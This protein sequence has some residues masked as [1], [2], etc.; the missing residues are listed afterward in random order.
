[1]FVSTCALAACAAAP[2]SDATTDAVRTGHSSIAEG[3]TGAVAA[4]V[5]LADPSSP[6][7]ASITPAEA[8]A[9]VAEVPGFG[10]D[11]SVDALGVLARFE[12]AA[13]APQVTPI[14]T[15]L[16]H[17]VEG[18]RIS[19]MTID[20]LTISSCNG[21]DV[22]A[23]FDPQGANYSGVTMV[24]SDDDWSNPH[25]VSLTLGS[26]GRWSA[27][28]QGL[29]PQRNLVF[30]L[31]LAQPTNDT[32]WLN[33]PRENQ[34]GASGHVDYR[35]AISLC[36]PV[37]TPTGEPFARL[38]QSFAR[39]ESLGGATVTGDELSWL[40]A[41]TTWEGGPG[42]DDPDVIDPTVAALD[43][44]SASGVAFEAGIY[45]NMRAFLEAMRMRRLKT[46]SAVSVQR[47]PLNQY[48]QL[49]APLGAQW[50]R[51]YYS[52]DGWSTPKVVECTPLGRGGYVSCGLGYLPVAALLSFS[53][54]V[55]YPGAPDEY[56][57][58]SDGGNIF[59]K[60]P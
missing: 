28:L 31:G 22:A 34:P 1:M 59:Q 35:Q 37:A 13:S 8:A 5:A 11:E 54:I 55:R 2:S 17:H 15:A 32:L 25:T 24:Y 36:E 20:G 9:Y 43:A 51:V 45:A 58:A 42:T 53:A 33:N 29:D 46:T 23:V 27:S 14:A 39:P 44:M 38:V 12:D 57:H 7:G 56:V 4:L 19:G 10:G 60:A 18:L 52:T 21:H 26:D 16:R 49:T 47:N 30:A 40:V 41:Q 50:M 3:P 6:G 48:L